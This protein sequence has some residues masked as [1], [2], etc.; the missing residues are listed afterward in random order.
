M[1]IGEKINQLR[2]M[3]KITLMELA[4]KSGV[5]QA[6]LSR[7]ENGKMIGT[8]ESHTHIAEALGVSLPELYGE[9]DIIQRD[10]V[11]QKS[12]EAASAFTHGK[13]GKAFILTKNVM[14]KKMMP[15]LLEIKAGGV[16]PMEE[17]SPDT[18]KFIY[19]LEGEIEVSVQE[20]IYALEPRDSLYFNAS[21]K[22]GIANRSDAG[23]KCL[24][25]AS[26][27]AL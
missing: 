20:K 25:V 22:H 1:N 9:V 19:C 18:E 16:A 10:I 12:Q 23:A 26:P 8:V 17:N 24:V 5:A 11:F 27:P 6:T 13:D 14:R 7:I 4:N 21:L 2:K 3:R 15:V